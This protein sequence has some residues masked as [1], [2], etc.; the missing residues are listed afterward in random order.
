MAASE[1]VTSQTA[2]Q[3]MFRVEF[4][5]FSRLP[6]T[7]A[8]LLTIHTFQRRLKTLSPAERQ[9]LARVIATCPEATLRYKGIF[10][11]LDSL[12]SWLAVDSA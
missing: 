9:R 2:A 10:P 4:Q 5:T 7:E 1:S 8:I 12:V 6:E 11:M 3:C